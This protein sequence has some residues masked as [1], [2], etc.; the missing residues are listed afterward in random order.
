LLDRGRLSPSVLRPVASIGSYWKNCLAD[1][2]ILTRSGLGISAMQHAAN[3]LLRKH[4]IYTILITPGT[5]LRN[6]PMAPFLNP[7]GATGV[8]A[9]ST[10]LSVLAVRGDGRRPS[11]NRVVAVNGDAADELRSA[12]VLFCRV[13]NEP[14]FLFAGAEQPLGELRTALRAY[15]NPGQKGVLR[16]L[17][18]TSAPVAELST[19]G[20]QLYGAAWDML[21]VLTSCRRPDIAPGI[22]H[23][24]TKAAHQLRQRALLA[25][26][27]ALLMLSTSASRSTRLLLAI[28]AWL[29]SDEVDVDRHAV[30]RLGRMLTTAL[31]EW[32][33]AAARASADLLLEEGFLQSEARH[34]QAVVALL[35]RGGPRLPDSVA[36][37][38]AKRLLEAGCWGHADTLFCSIV[39]SAADE[40]PS[41][42]LVRRIQGLRICGEYSLSAAARR[43]E[44]SV[45]K[46][47]RLVRTTAPQAVTSEN[48]LSVL[49]QAGAL[50]I[51]AESPRAAVV[52][53]AQWLRQEQGGL[54]LFDEIA[55]LCPDISAEQK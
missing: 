36:R 16:D 3:L 47:R 11:A 13:W 46:A 29:S 20:A 9:R 35:Q 23:D 41:H 24:Y 17:V 33:Q 31:E 52:P 7:V 8:E 43:L 15:Q 44:I 14:P 42:I 45:H 39:R 1:A 32:Q 40:L 37:R 22:W 2:D 27:L 26:E 6:H 53:M 5:R 25:A 49:F 12:A 48:I 21:D 30:E 50:P 38:C 4:G 34:A 54:A 55:L 10:A 19:V 28:D 18:V 51:P